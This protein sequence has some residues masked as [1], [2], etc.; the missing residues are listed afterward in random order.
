MN[1]EELDAWFA[2]ADDV[3]TDWHCSPD[4]MNTATALPVVMRSIDPDVLRRFVAAIQ[5]V[6]E[7]AIR[8]VNTAMPVLKDLH[9][10]LREAGVLPDE[11][12]KDDARARAL[13]LRQHR[14]TGPALTV[15][16]DGRRRGRTP[17]DR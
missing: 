11:P 12:P 13:W 2:Q 4:S 5:A 10:V 7:A 17:S 15:G 1:R 8:Y 3:L 6:G 14:N 9:R 16:L